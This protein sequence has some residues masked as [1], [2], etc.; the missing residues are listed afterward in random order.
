MNDTTAMFWQASRAMGRQHAR[1]A[2]VP[3]TPLCWSYRS[4]VGPALE[5]PTNPCRQCV[6]KAAGLT[7]QEIAELV[8]DEPRIAALRGLEIGR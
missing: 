7:D 1:L 3:R 6:S 4:A 2:A 5:T 8:G